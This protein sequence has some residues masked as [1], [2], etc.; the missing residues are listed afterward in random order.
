MIIKKIDLERSLVL[1]SI[2]N[3]TAFNADRIQTLKYGI[4]YKGRILGKKYDNYYVLLDNIWIEIP[5]E[6]IS[7]YKTGDS[8]EVLKASSTLFFDA[9]DAN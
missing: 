4:E 5:V 7:I 8:I 6:S 9:K 3:L 1:L 2:K